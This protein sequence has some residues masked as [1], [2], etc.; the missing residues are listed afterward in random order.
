[1]SG[2]GLTLSLAAGAPVSRMKPP[3]P[4]PGFV[5]LVD[6]DGVYL[7]DGDGAYFVEPV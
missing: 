3:V 1:M 4:P 7:V 2:L 6:H 5:F